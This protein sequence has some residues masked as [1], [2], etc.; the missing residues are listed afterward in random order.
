MNICSKQVNNVYFLEHS[1]KIRPT[2][3]YT[4]INSN[5]VSNYK[6]I[7]LKVPFNYNVMNIIADRNI[8]H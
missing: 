1:T 8:G 5:H 3:M 2:F 6:I 7:T 4:T